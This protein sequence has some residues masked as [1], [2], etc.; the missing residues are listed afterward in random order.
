MFKCDLQACQCIATLDA[1]VQ[2]V[3][4]VVNLVEKSSHDR[5]TDA[6]DPVVRRT[7]TFTFAI[8]CCAGA[9]GAILKCHATCASRQLDA[10]AVV[11]E[12]L[13]VKCQEVVEVS[14]E[15]SLWGRP[16]M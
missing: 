7:S 13:I 9:L 3:F 4:G 6:N 2:V 16:T 11:E 5:L 14:G 10:Q 1:S 8:A 15:P 12:G